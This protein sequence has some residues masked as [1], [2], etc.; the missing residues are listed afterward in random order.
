MTINVILKYNIVFNVNIFDIIEVNV[1][2]GLD[3]KGHVNVEFAN[4]NCTFGEED[5]PMLSRFKDIIMPALDKDIRR[6]YKGDTYLLDNIEVVEIEGIGLVLLGIHVKNTE[7]EIKSR[8]VEGKGIVPTDQK[9]PAGPYSGFAIILSNHRMIHIK[10]QKGSPTIIQFGATFRHIINES[11][12][13]YN[14]IQRKAD[15]KYWPY[16]DIN[17]TKI[18]NQLSLSNLFNQIEKIDRLKLSLFPLNG[19]LDNSA[20]VEAIRSRMNP[21]GSKTA[22]VTYNTPDNKD[23]VQELV[24]D[25]ADMA[26]VTMV[27]QLKNGNKRTFKNEDYSEV[28]P[29]YLPEEEDDINTN[30]IYALNETK[31][32]T[33]LREVST[34]NREIYSKFKD[35]ILS[36][37]KRS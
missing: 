21:I 13:D 5:K 22:N 20:M 1:F 6:E 36:F 15:K 29:M 26:S 14:D 27:T 12:R 25:V 33:A 17:I 19:D 16:A 31:G 10:N 11:V 8:Y 28:I 7:L 23:N 37:V 18:P 3:M 32:H 35:I 34:L 24:A 4:L 30:I 2:W 9:I